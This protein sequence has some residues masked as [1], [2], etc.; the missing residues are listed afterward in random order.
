MSSDVSADANK[1]NA[2]SN[3]ATVPGNNRQGNVSNI[4]AT[5]SS[6]AR[7]NM[8]LEIKRD[9]GNSDE[10]HL[11][12]ATK[13][14][15]GNTDAKEHKQ[16]ETK[17]HTSNTDVRNQYSVASKHKTDDIESREHVSVATK[18]HAGNMDASKQHYFT[19]S[20]SMSSSI[21]PKYGQKHRDSSKTGRLKPTRE[22]YKPP[23]NNQ[24]NPTAKEFAPLQTSKSYDF[25][26]KGKG[27]SFNAGGPPNG[28][29]SGS[30]SGPPS[31]PQDNIVLN[32]TGLTITIGANKQQGNG[33]TKSR[34][35]SSQMTLPQSSLSP[36]EFTESRQFGLSPA[37]GSSNIQELHKFSF[38]VP[39]ENRQIHQQQQH[40]RESRQSHFSGGLEMRQQSFNGGPDMMAVNDWR[41][42]IDMDAFSFPQEIVSTISKAMDDPN[43]VPG[44]SLMELVKLIINRIISGTSSNHQQNKKEAPSITEQAAMLCTGIIQHEDRKTFQESLINTCQ[45]IYHDR[46]RLL[47]Q[48]ISRWNSYISFLN[49]MYGKLKRRQSLTMEKGS[50]RE[51][52]APRFVLLSLLAECCTCTLTS[53]LQSLSEVE[54]MFGVLTTIGRDLE[55]EMPG[56]MGLLVTCLREAFLNY[57][58]NHQVSKLLLQ[59][60]E[61]EAAGW[62]LPAQAVMYYYPGAT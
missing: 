1:M 29:P 12:M 58:L 26:N 4:Q 49:H 34:S 39:P 38:E 14:Q 37:T 60:I 10:E 42:Q 24:L 23:V 31:G 30:H 5:K 50:E 59:L 41:H 19:R 15:T 28:P 2:P 43:R 33:L 32:R 57:R 46:E 16:L 13:Y 44:R 8:T 51:G 62:T 35:I 27:D 9:P 25:A 11:F 55:A 56:R 36:P 17:L 21:S 18:Q 47:R 54:T 3:V 6:N 20:F 7:D 53:N 45:E 48:D 52:V 61:L 40:F 22:L